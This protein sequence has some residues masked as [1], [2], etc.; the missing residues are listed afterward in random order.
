MHIVKDHPTLPHDAEIHPLGWLLIDTDSKVALPLPVQQVK[1]VINQ[2]GEVTRTGPAAGPR[3]PQ[4][5]LNARVVFSRIGP[6]TVPRTTRSHLKVGDTSPSR[7]KRSAQRCARVAARIFRTRPR[8]RQNG[9]RLEV[10]R[11]M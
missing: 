9:I 5:G 8:P 1:N 3:V 7:E 4:V 10:D 11:R 2:T 6:R